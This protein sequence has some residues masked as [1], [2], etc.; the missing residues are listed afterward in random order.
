MSYTSFTPVLLSYTGYIKNAGSPQ[1]I[2]T[3]QLPVTSGRWICS[4]PIIAHLGGTG[5]IGSLNQTYVIY[6]GP[7]AGGT[8]MASISSASA[9]T[10]GMARVIGSTVTGWAF[11]T[12]VT[13]RQTVDSLFTGAIVGLTLP[14]WPVPGT[15]PFQSF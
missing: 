4:G 6:S 10:S 14:M 1:D 15:G 2:A 7:S 8:N 3:L 11:T 5:D 13:I 12:G 9:I